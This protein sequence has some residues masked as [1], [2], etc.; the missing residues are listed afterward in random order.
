MRADRILL[1]GLSCGAPAEHFAD[2]ATPRFE[3][4]PA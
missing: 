4:L 2:F 3:E 1:I